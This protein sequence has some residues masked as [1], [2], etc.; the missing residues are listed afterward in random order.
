ME[1]DQLLDLQ[2]KA[3]EQQI[4]LTHDSLGKHLDESERIH[5]RDAS[6]TIVNI[7]KALSLDP[8]N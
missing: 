3:C 2:I 8:T 5:A 1:P 4:R 6:Q 7:A